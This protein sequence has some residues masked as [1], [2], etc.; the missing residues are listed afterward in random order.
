MM[1][2]NIAL[3]NYAT[4]E[5]GLSKTDFTIVSRS[6]KR[7][8]KKG[9]ELLLVKDLTTTHEGNFKVYDAL[10]GGRKETSDEFEVSLEEQPAT[11]YYRKYGDPDTHTNYTPEPEYW[12]YVATAVLVVMTVT[13]I[14]LYTK[15]VL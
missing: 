10:S 8:I 13:T 4:D 6:S 14:I 2:S 5:L 3:E 15:G 1:T 12:Q 9:G 11:E 7:L